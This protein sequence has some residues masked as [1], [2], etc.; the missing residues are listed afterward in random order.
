[1]KRQCADNNPKIILRKY[2][3]DGKIVELSLCKQHIQDPDFS[4]FISEEIL[5]P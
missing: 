1:M 3:W 5:I 2:N 4:N